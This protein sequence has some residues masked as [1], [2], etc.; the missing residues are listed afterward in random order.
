[1]IERTL[2]PHALRGKVPRVH[3]ML[4]SI[5]FVSPCC[6]I[7]PPT[8]Q[9]RAGLTSLGKEG[10]PTT[11]PATTN[12]RLPSRCVC[13]P[14]HKTTDAE[15]AEA[16]RNDQEP[17]FM[18]RDTRA[19]SQTPG[20]AEQQTGSRTMR[21]PLVVPNFV[22]RLSHYARRQKAVAPVEHPYALPR[23]GRGDPYYRQRVHAHGVEKDRA[24]G[25]RSGNTRRPGKRRAGSRG[26]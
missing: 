21:P 5:E 18:P 20:P 6:S 17:F 16:A 4:C 22:K 11:S 24:F 23:W 19:P 12:I 25:R 9:R 2:C 3:R 8:A 26:T 1:M 10:N 7:E 14:R 13:T 15:R